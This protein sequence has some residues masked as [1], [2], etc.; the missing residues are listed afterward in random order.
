MRTYQICVLTNMSIQHIIT[1]LEFCLKNA[2]FSSKVSIMNKFKVQPWLL[3]SGLSLP[4]CLW[5]NPSSR[6]FALPHTALS[7][8]KVCWYL[9]HPEGRTQPT[10]SSSHQH[11]RTTHT[12]HHGG[13]KPRWITSIPEHPGFTRS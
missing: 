13:T 2:Y 8:A 5:K 11:T 9:C 4:T 1:L 10:T 12:V 7:M 6:P 3:P